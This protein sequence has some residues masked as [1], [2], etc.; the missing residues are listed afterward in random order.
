MEITCYREKELLRETRHLP[1]ATY[2]LAIKLLA[3]SKTGN[4]FLPIRAMQYLAILDDREFIFIDGERRSL[5]DIAWQHFHPQKRETLDEP[6]EYE[7]AYYFE[8]SKDLMNRL[9]S[10]FHKALLAAEEKDRIETPAKVLKFEI[11]R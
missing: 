7:A 5:I 4:V 2:N 10:E 1:A 3:R 8:H 6:V 9:Q 11:K